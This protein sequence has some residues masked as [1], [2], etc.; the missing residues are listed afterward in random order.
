MKVHRFTVR[1]RTVALT[2]LLL[3]SLST[4]GRSAIAFDPN[5][6]P[7]VRGNYFDGWYNATSTNRYI[8][9]SALITVRTGD[10]CDGNP[11][12]NLDTGNYNVA[13]S[14][15]ASGN[16]QGWAQSGYARSW[17]TAKYH[18]SQQ[19]GGYASDPIL[20]NYCTSCGA[21][22]NGEIHKY[23]QQWDPVNKRWN[24][25][26]DNTIFGSTPSYFPSHWSRPYSPQFAGETAYLANNIPGS[27]TARTKFDQMSVQSFQ[28]FQWGPQP[29]PDGQHDISVNSNT[30]RWASAGVSC[31]SPTAQTIWTK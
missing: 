31:N 16:S 18:F 2:L 5:C 11:D 29:C 14:M 26:V 30:A 28:D 7:S 27:P 4:T 1:I 10:V 13:W 20:D 15:I 24:S 17:G 19:F 22:A 9:S 23:W 3:L 21:L 6:N 25:N 12:P 8:G